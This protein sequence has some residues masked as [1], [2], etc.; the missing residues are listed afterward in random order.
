MHSF[1]IKFA[2]LSAASLLVIPAMAQNELPVT[3]AFKCTD[4]TAF[5]ARYADNSVRLYLPGKTVKLPRTRSASG[6]RYADGKTIYWTKGDEAM[7][8]RRGFAA[9]DCKID[10]KA[11]VWE[12]A[13][14]DGADFRAIGDESG[15]ELLI[16]SD[17]MIL[18]ADYSTT[19][20]VFK[21]ASIFEDRRK[22]RTTYHAHTKEHSISVTL[23][24]GPCKST[25]SDD[26]YETK[27]TI[28][29]DQ[30]RTLNGCGKA[31]H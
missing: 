26:V 18:T 20:L 28:L 15:W 10:T 14:L 9:S 31:L 6:A 8:I 2:C 23:S 7:L 5:T 4:G 13:K 16:F 27:V 3:A 19:N 17:A 11:T 30:E 22:N 12:A 24:R 21:D 29:L 1:V 25:M